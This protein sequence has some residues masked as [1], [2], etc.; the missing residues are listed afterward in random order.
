MET[1]GRRDFITQLSLATAAVTFP[2]YGFSGV[3]KA[4]EFVQVETTHGRIKGMR[5]EG[6]SVFKGVPYGGRI[7]G[8]RRFRRPAPLES[9]TGVRVAT[10][11]LRPKIVCS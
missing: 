5:N 6:V 8:D 7:S 2:H 4:D 11:R 1:I 9:W 10:N 3:S